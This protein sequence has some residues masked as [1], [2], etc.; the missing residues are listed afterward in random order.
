MRKTDGKRWRQNENKMAITTTQIITWGILLG[1]A[2]LFLFAIVSLL[3]KGKGIKRKF[4]HLFKKGDIT[5]AYNFAVVNLYEP[6]FSTFPKRIEQ[7][8]KQGFHNPSIIEY[9]EEDLNKYR[10]VEDAREFIAGAIQDGYSFREAKR[11]ALQYGHN[12]KILKIALKLN[13]KEGNYGVQ[14]ERQVPRTERQTGSY[15][16]ARFKATRTSDGRGRD[17]R[18]AI[19]TNGRGRGIEPRREPIREPRYDGEITT[20]IPIGADV[21]RWAGGTGTRVEPR[22]NGRVEQTRTDARNKPRSIASPTTTTQTQP[23]T[24][25]SGSAR[26]SVNSQPARQRNIQARDV[27]KPNKVSGYFG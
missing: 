12:K 20:T 16:D 11:L 10:Q 3:G 5:K 9:A 4:Y 1:L 13:K 6:D 15:E 22:R 23:R 21:E 17:G 2:V 24:V 8:I 27:K 7:Y 19:A 18:S 26:T 14:K 25:K